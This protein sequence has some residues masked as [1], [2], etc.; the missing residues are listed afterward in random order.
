M[1][2]A[3]IDENGQDYRSFADFMKDVCGGTSA[4]GHEFGLLDRSN[5][6]S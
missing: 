4:E 6:R 5:L 3:R 2:S 1:N